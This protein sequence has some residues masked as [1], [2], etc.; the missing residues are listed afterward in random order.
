M[1]LKNKM[2]II[3]GITLLIIF[4]N[5]AVIQKGNNNFLENDHNLKDEIE[6]NSIDSAKQQWKAFKVNYLTS[7]LFKFHL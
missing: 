6:N 4:V 2:F 1:I 5:S 7:F 3:Y